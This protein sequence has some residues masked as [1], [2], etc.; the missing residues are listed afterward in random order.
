MRYGASLVEL[1]AFGAAIPQGHTLMRFLVVCV[2]SVIVFV[3]YKS[4]SR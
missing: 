3:Y 4:W 2:V 1:V